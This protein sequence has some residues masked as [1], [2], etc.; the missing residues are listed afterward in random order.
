MIHGYKYLPGHPHHCPHLGILSPAPQV[1]TGTPSWPRQLGFGAG[2]PGEG[3]AIAFGWDARGALWT[4]E[5]QA[6]RAGRALAQVIGRLHTAAPGRPVHLVAHSMGTEL[7]LEALHHLPP[8]AIGRILSLTGACYQSRVAGALATPAGRRAEFVNITSRENDAFD[9][10]YERLIAPPAAGDRAIGQGLDLPNL[11]TLQLDCS[12]TLA[13]L[14]R[15]DCPVGGSARRICHWS[16][17]TRPGVL[18]FYERLIRQPGIFTLDR[19]RRG[20][21]ESPEKRW[22]RLMSLPSLPRPLP[23]GIEAS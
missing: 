13:H 23:S 9:F 6:R 14:E 16:S 7:A 18:R 8:G 20:L 3:L 19:L 15:L 12:R 1:G 17:Y 21:P 2:L 10:L 22:S 5:R 11:L 4:A